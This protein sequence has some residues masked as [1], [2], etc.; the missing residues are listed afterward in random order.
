MKIIIIGA[1]PA[2][3]SAVE[4]FRLFDRQSELT[5]LTDEPYL[6]YSPPAMADHFILGSKLHLW[7]S[8]DWLDQ[9]GVEYKHK[10]HVSTIDPKAH[11]IFLESGEVLSFDK[12]VIATGARLFAPLEGA[13]MPGVYNFK[14]LGAAENLVAKVRSGHGRT[15]T[16]VGAG[17]IGMEIALLL[18][19]LGV[20][21][22]QIEMLDQVMATMLD[23][24][25]AAIALEL[26]RKRGVEVRLN[27]KAV[28][29][30]GEGEA[31]GVQ[32]ESGEVLRSDLIIAA[33]GVKPNLDLLAGSGIDFL[34]GIRVD[35][36]LQTNQADIYAAGD[37]LET[38]NRITGETMVHAIFPNA[39]EQGRVVGMNLAG[40]A[41]AY[42]G[43]ERMNSLKHLGLPIIAAG[44]KHGDQVLTDTRNGTHRAIYL[45]DNCLVGFQLVGN[46]RAAGVLHE[47]MV[48]RSDVTSLQ[49]HLLDPNFGEGMLAWKAISTV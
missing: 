4:T 14:S 27:T 6:P 26:M 36:Y 13:E 18:C 5:M 38:P 48:Q 21:V 3:V 25:T 33:T 45:E 20:K 16:I 46:I 17:F 43:A 37:C 28:A 35:A 9:M 39:V 34:R 23:A 29:I 8:P 42:E 49:S 7:R 40:H 44:E 10:V 2:G 47:L 32:L 31:D 22:T 19:E 24:D 11:R 41:I 1:G 15:A 30:T 12:L